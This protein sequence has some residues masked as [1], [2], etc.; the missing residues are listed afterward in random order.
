M[1]NERKSIVTRSVE[2]FNIPS[3][4][5]SQ[6]H[7]PRDHRQ[8]KLIT[9]YSHQFYFTVLFFVDGWKIALIR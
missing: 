2:H 4:I 5:I 1:S 3:S 7:Q 6:F 8:R 9:I